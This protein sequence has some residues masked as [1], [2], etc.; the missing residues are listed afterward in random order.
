MA[1]FIL[2]PPDKYKGKQVII[3][4]DRL[5]FNSKTDAILMFSSKAIG[6]SSAGTLN[7]DSDKECIISSPKIQLGLKAGEPLILGNQAEKWLKELIQGLQFLV[8]SLEDN[9]VVIGKF[10]YPNMSVASPSQNLSEVLN[11]LLNRIKD[12]KSTTSYTN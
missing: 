9:G 3:S 12:I 8:K 4:S 10:E 5:V 7:F 6:L 2:S 11:D 1:N